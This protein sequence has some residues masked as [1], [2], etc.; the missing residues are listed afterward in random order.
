MYGRLVNLRRLRV[1]ITN[2]KPVH[3]EYKLI[4]KENYAFSRSKIIELI[5]EL[6]SEH[7]KYYLNVVLVN[8]IPLDTLNEGSHFYS[9][10]D[11]RGSIPAFLLLKM[12]NVILNK[13]QLSYKNSSL[14]IPTRKKDRQIKLQR[15]LKV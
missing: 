10:F 5:Q 1:K 2:V 4:D 6:L 12:E 7:I 11:C 13:A 3:K 14:R 8:H 15:L 9:K